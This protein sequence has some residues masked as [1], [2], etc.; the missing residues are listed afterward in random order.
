M[1]SYGSNLPKPVQSPWEQIDRGLPDQSDL[2]PGLN[3]N[4][5]NSINYGSYGSG[6]FDARMDAYLRVGGYSEHL[7][8]ENWWHCKK[9]SD[10]IR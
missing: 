7:I 5:K 2:D 10:W 3:F 8:F 1:S 4:G 6:V 9:Q